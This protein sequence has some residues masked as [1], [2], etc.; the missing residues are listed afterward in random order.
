[1]AIAAAA[2]VVFR[3]PAVRNAASRGASEAKAACSPFRIASRSPLAPR[4]FRCPVELIACVESMQ[5]YHT[6]TASALMTSMLTVSPRS[7]GWLAK[8]INDDA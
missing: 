7:F 5:P 6:A 2:R 8:A 4:I 3:S 1:M